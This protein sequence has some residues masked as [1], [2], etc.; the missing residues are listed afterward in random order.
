MTRAF[1]VDG[2][3]LNVSGR[4]LVQSVI[5]DSVVVQYTGSTYTGGGS[6]WS[7]E[8]TAD[9]AQDAALSGGISESQLSDGAEALATD[10]TDDQGLFPIPSE[11]DGNG[12]QSF[13][14]E[15]ALQYT[16]NEDFDYWFGV[17]GTN[18]LAALAD[19]DESASNNGQIRFRLFDSDTN[20]QTFAPASNPNLDDGNR[21]D[22]SLIVNDAATED[23]EII[24]DGT[25]YAVSIGNDT[26]TADNFGDFSNDMGLFCRNQSSGT[27]KHK[28]GNVGAFVMH[29]TNISSQYVSSL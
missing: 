27:G 25:S 15:M 6:S 8:A 29:K 26:G 12:L 2:R 7:D 20:G 17:N 5:P 24:I 13:T 3:V 19:V 4:A 11:L 21:H 10:G 23:Y 14:V 9:G 16:T 1:G 22:I 28:T 18:I